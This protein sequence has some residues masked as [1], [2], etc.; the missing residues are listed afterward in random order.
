MIVWGGRGATAYES[1]GIYDPVADGWIPMPGEPPSPRDGHTAVWTGSRM[2]VWGG[3]DTQATATG[4]IYDPA[5]GSWAPTS[6]TNAPAPRTSHAAVWTGGLMIVWGGSPEAG[7]G[8]RYAHGQDLDLDGDGVTPCS[9]DCDESDASV[10]PGAPQLCD[11]KQNDCSDSSWPAPPAAEADADGDG[12][13]VCAGDCDDLDARTYPG[14]PEHNDGKDNQCPGDSG[15]GT[16][17]EIPYASFAD[18]ADKTAY[19]WTAQSG[20]ALYEVAR[21]L[22][23]DFTLDCRVFATADALLA[24]A[25]TP[26]AG[27]VYFY[28]VRAAAPFAGSWG[29]ASSDAER[30]PVC[31]SP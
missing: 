11:G 20:A 30:T 1:G 26:P 23:P 19:S 14:A 8:G 12:A 18:P 9:G 2:I 29:V 5:A 31:A 25:E 22:D 21:S 13:R 7:S 10:F 3:Y 28:L 4:G 6:A 15:F 16:A 27:E 17:D 24:D